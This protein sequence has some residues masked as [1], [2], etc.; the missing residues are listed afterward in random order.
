M[1]KQSKKQIYQTFTFTICKTNLPVG[2]YWKNVALS[3]DCTNLGQVKT[4]SNIF[5]VR[6]S[7]LVNNIYF[8]KEFIDGAL[9][10]NVLINN[11]TPKGNRSKFQNNGCIWE[12]V[13]YTNEPMK[14]LFRLPRARYMC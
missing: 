4:S 10:R 12:V 3:P 14:S 1:N 5:P 2:P 11:V 13:A 9:A 6:I 8:L 7:C